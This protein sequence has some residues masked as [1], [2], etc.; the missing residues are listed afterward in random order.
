MYLFVQLVLTC[1]PVHS[2]SGDGCVPQ[3][4]PELLVQPQGLLPRQD[5][6]RR[7]LPGTD[8]FYHWPWTGFSWTWTKFPLSQVIFPVLYCIIVYWM[9]EQP[10]D[11]ARFFLFVSLGVLTS[12]VAQSLGLLIGAASTS[13]QVT[14]HPEVCFK[15]SL[16]KESSVL[17]DW[18]YPDSQISE[19]LLSIHLFKRPWIPE[20]WSSL[21]SKF[22]P[23][24]SVLYLLELFHVLHCL[25]GDLKLS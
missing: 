19:Y 11:A 9:T 13:L 1:V 16:D 17:F 25:D 6:G 12:L 18:D 15:P 14:F 8:G 23:G 3:R 22:H 5:Y 4:T 21:V 7:A 24:S 2:S 20:S 10:P